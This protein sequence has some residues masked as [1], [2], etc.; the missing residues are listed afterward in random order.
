MTA[1]TRR[2]LWLLAGAAAAALFVRA[3]RAPPVLV[4]TALVE[5][6][7]LE[8]TVEDDGRTRVRERYVVSAPIDG[9]LLRVPLDPGANVVA[10]ETV[11]AEFEPRAAVPLDARARAQAQA[12]A[13][14]AA[15]ALERA[16]AEEAS[17][18]AAWEYARIDL[19][20][21]RQLSESGIEQQAR[22][23]QAMRDERGAGEAVRAARFQVL[24]ARHELEAARAL[25]EEDGEEGRKV[26]LL[27]SPIDGVVLRLREES[28]RTLAAGAPIL[29]VGD[30]SR[31]EIV[32]DLLSQDAV[33]V[34]P[35]MTVEVLGWGG[36][37]G[38]G[39]SRLR[40]VVRHVE[41]AGYTK[42]SALGVE[43]Q[44]VDVIVDPVG[45]WDELRD[46]YRVEVRI[47][48]WRG[49]DVRIVPT[50]AL[51]RE[52][53]S[54][55]AYVVEDDRAVARALEIGRRGGLEAEVLSGLAEGEQVVLYPSELIEPGTAVEVRQF[56]AR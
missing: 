51:F 25:L 16:R 7:A 1:W 44:R 14:A 47:V 52:G 10:G 56:G 15:A 8:V 5:R 43:E 55:S 33:A 32:A 13:E 12:R 36:P 18:Q 21:R 46:G 31:L 35:G 48:V 39:E 27:R 41:P 50:G 37:E 9:Q 23:D 24:V 20:R 22:V 53:G 45:S 30:V 17:A 2:S 11:L 4:D 6:G 26:L 54:W 19:A 28:S 34:R 38:T 29:E 3:F 40:G 49:D 42:I